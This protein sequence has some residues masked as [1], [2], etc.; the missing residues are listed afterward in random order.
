MTSTFLGQLHSSLARSFTIEVTGTFVS[1]ELA[2]PREE[3]GE[4]IKLQLFN[5]TP[6]TSGLITHHHS[7]IISLANG[8]NFPVNLLVT[9]LHNAM[10]IILGLPWLH[11]A[12]SDIDW[13]SMT[14]TFEAGNA[15]LAAS[16]FLKSRSAL[17]IKE[18]IDKDCPKPPNPESIHQP[19]L[20]NPIP[21]HTTSL[22]Q[23]SQ[24]RDDIAQPQ[25]DAILLSTPSPTF[26]KPN[27]KPPP[28][29]P[30]NLD[31]G[32]ISTASFAQIIQKS[33]QACQLHISPSLPEEHLQADANI[34]APE[35][36]LED[37][38]LCE[39]VP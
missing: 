2:L 17:I 6:T 25:N 7:N 39:V 20:A 32:I 34:P 19:I 33:A 21:S 38:T 23:P 24:P 9:Q 35:T 29:L 13:K 11:D 12:N 16:F 27:P 31:I 37:Q 5:S 1:L 15:Q 36:K 8:L 26:S 18:A 10:P 28:E 14:M 30:N 22:E 3:I 4:L